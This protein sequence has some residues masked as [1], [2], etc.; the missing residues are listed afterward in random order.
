MVKVAD[1]KPFHEPVRVKDACG[2][3]GTFAPECLVPVG[4]LAVPMCWLCAHHVVEHD[5]PL[6]AAHCAE[7]ECTPREIYPHRVFDE[8]GQVTAQPEP[9]SPRAAEREKILHSSSKELQAWAREAHKQ[10][11]D[12]QLRA[13]KKRLS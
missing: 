1:L 5:A 4:E 9:L 6:A 12:A 7:C 11:S 3:C 8:P 10:L 13:V 2:A